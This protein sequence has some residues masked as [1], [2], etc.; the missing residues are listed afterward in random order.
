[1]IL[2]VLA[3]DSEN[4]HKKYLNLAPYRFELGFSSEEGIF[5]TEFKILLCTLCIFGWQT[6]KKQH[7]IKPNSALHYICPCA[8]SPPPSDMCCNKNKIYHDRSFYN[9]LPMLTT[10]SSQHLLSSM[11]MSFDFAKHKIY[12]LSLYLL[13]FLGQVWL[14]KI[15]AEGEETVVLMLNCQQV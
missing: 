2:V 10:I 6:G 9:T 11:T 4:I 14:K 3:T 5:K 13:T 15:S 1:M 7:F 8:T 12:A